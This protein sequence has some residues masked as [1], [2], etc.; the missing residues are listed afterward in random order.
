MANLTIIIIIIINNNNNSQSCLSVTELNCLSFS[1]RRHPPWVWNNPRGPR[2]GPA[3][4]LEGR[5]PVGGGGG[6]A[7]LHGGG[8]Q[9][10]AEAAAG[11]PQQEKRRGTRR[12][13][14]EFFL[15]REGPKGP[16]YAIS[17]LTSDFSIVMRYCPH[18]MFRRH[19]HTKTPPP[20]T[21][22]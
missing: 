8:G 16:A 15:F 17:L 10:E 9:E 11:R 4:G 13:R 3:Q 22:P 2:E 18:Y 20:Y 14:V 19:T 6:G 7:L 5:V 12:I 1:V 21:H